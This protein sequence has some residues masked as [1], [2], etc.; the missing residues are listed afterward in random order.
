MY[1]LTTFS[2]GRLYMQSKIIWVLKTTVLLGH[3]PEV[4]IVCNNNLGS[5]KKKT[6]K[7]PQHWFTEANQINAF[8]LQLLFFTS[9]LNLFSCYGEAIVISNT[10][11]SEATLNE[12]SSSA[13]GYTNNDISGFIGK[14]KKI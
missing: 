3:R 4:A 9:I 8:R 12:F 14:E 7:T 6:K 10:L 11:I 1:M 13:Q 5:W 2:Q